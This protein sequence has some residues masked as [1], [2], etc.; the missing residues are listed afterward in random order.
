MFKKNLIILIGLLSLAPSTF[1]ARPLTTDDA[2]TVDPQ[3]FELE[4]GYDFNK[5]QD[6]SEDKSVNVSLKHGITERLDLCIALP[7]EVKPEQGLG[8][9]EVGMKFSLLKEKENIPGVSF[10][11]SPRLGASEYALNGILSKKIGQ[12]NAHLNLGYVATGKV[13]EKGVTIYSG[14]IELPLSKN[15]VLVGEIVGEADADS[16]TKDILIGL[17]GGSLQVLD[18]LVLDLG[19][20][21]GFNDASPKWKMTLGLTYGF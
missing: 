18:A 11:F 16:N 2:G 10:T 17:L 12:I 5:N 20:S 7:Y 3:T 4:M 13:D 6:N 15:L 8:S 1:A 14:A 9:A 19:I 21:T